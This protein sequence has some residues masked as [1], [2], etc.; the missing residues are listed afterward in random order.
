MLCGM[1]MN[2]TCFRKWV[3][4]NISG[5]AIGSTCYAFIYITWLVNTAAHCDTLQHIATHMLRI[6][7][8]DMTRTHCNTLQHTAT[9]MLRIHIYDM[10]RTHCNI[11]WHTATHCNTHVTHSYIWHD[12]FI[13]IPCTCLAGMYM[14]RDAFIYMPWHM[15]WLV[16]IRHTTRLC[17]WHDSFIQI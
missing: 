8:Y 9:H 3:F 11:L 5:G 4:K 14:L 6:H 13:R 16:H 2:E 1:C 12:S 7:T 17:V 10:T 15:T